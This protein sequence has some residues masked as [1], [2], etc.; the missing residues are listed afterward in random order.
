MGGYLNQ[1]DKT[2]EK[3]LGDWFRTGDHFALREDGRLVFLERMDDLRVLA[4]GHRYPP[5]FIETRLRF[6]PFIKDVMTVG[7]ERRHFVV[8]LINIDGEMVTRWAE[9]R[10]ITFSTF[11]DLSQRPQIRSLI[12]AE[13]EQVNKFLPAG[14]RVC[15]FVNLP[16]ELDPDEGELTRTRK[17]RRDFL[18]ERYGALIDGLY[19]GDSEVHFDIAIR[20][21]DGRRGTMQA[22]AHANQVQAPPAVPVQEPVRAV[23]AAVVEARSA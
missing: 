5:Q 17:L 18:A 9:E 3:Y 1:P 12:Q 14:S 22:V 15:R 19:R 13:I 20:Y 4:T 7:D 10:G 2:A 6:S 21:Q 8:A 11:A 16:K 23:M